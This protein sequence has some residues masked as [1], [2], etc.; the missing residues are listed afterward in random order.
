VWFAAEQP[1]DTKF[2]ARDT[3]TAGAVL[4]GPLVV[5]QFD[6]TTLVPPGSRVTVLES[7]SLLIEVDA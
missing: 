4:E 2:I 7:G 6:A 5:T 1:T 3:L